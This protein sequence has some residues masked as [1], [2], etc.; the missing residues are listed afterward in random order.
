MLQR[1]VSGE[2][3]GNEAEEFL[4]GQKKEREREKR[5]KLFRK[6]RSQIITSPSSVFVFFSILLSPVIGPRD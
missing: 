3:G 2:V 4:F 1:G 5:G 6:V